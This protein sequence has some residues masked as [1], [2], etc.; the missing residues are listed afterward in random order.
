[1]CKLVAVIRSCVMYY[2]IIIEQGRQERE[3]MHK[4]F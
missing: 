2:V 4:Y 3:N 1:M